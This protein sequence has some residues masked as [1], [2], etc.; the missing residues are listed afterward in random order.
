MCLDRIL[1]FHESVGMDRVILSPWVSLLNY[2]RPA[3]EGLRISRIQNEALARIAQ[4]HGGRV[5]ALGTVP[6]Q[7]PDLAADELHEIMREPG[8]CGVEVAASVNGEYLGADRFEPFWEAAEAIGAIVF[9][10]PTTRGFNL[11]VMNDF[12]LWNT[13]GNPLETAV[14]AAHLVM[15]G[16]LERHPCL[17]IILAHGGGAILALRGRLR[18]AHA[19]QPQARARLTENPEDS[20]KRLYY[21]SL[22][23]DPH[24]L[25]ALIEYVGEERVLLGS[26]YPF[27][28]GDDDA[29]GSIRRLGLTPD[30]EDMIL[31]RNAAR[32]FDMED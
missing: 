10:H 29:V 27:D 26:D 23:H 1:E 24:L 30:A 7:A 19:F 2:D 12:Y 31:H 8:L 6:L 5:F 20:L 11:P 4:Q 17:K 22:T 13:V 32:L 3:E 9:I 21:D 16:V 15:A 25:R 28:M 14:T 18:H